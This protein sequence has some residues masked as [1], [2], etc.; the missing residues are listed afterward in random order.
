M[1][2]QKG[3]QFGLLNPEVSGA[4]IRSAAIPVKHKF[5]VA[6]ARVAL[7]Y[8]TFKQNA[9]D[10]GFTDA[11][12]ENLSDFE[13]NFWIAQAFSRPGGDL[14]DKNNG[15]FGHK[16][17]LSYLKDHGKK[18]SDI[19]EIVHFTGTNKAT[20]DIALATAAIITALESK[21]EEYGRREEYRRIKSHNI[22]EAQLHSSNPNHIPP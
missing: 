8:D 18:L 21:M 14:W 20:T 6:S 12:I 16:T 13:R 22:H 19:S 10:F 7:A 11:D 2:F 3:Y 9:K 17:I 1:R 4:T 15:K 5:L